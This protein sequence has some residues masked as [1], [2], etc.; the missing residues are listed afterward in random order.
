[1]GK[2]K[3]KDKNRHLKEKIRRLEDRLNR[4]SS[5]DSATDEG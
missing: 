4:F 1:M 5:S 2:R 3:R